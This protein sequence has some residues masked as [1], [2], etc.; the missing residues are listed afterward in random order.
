MGTTYLR[1]WREQSGLT[2]K[3]LA[4]RIKRSWQTVHRWETGRTQIKDSDMARLLALFDITREELLFGPAFAA[5]RLLP[6]PEGF[7]EDAAPYDP[8]ALPGMT[9]HLADTEFLFQVKSDAV[10]AS[11]ERLQSGDFAVFDCGARALDHLQ[12]GGFPDGVIV[13]A[14]VYDDATASADTIIRQW[15]GPWPGVLFTNRHGQNQIATL[16]LRDNIQCKGVLK[17][18]LRSHTDQPALP[19]PD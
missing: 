1:Y 18:S 14:Q 17:R 19:A 6:A 13:L 15:A 10:A 5:P 3:Q 12:A 7:S 4:A 2:Q 16:S 9:L 11:R 8:A